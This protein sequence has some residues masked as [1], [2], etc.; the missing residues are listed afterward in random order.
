MPSKLWSDLAPGDELV[1]DDHWPLFATA[2]RRGA[3]V[4]ERI[5][6]ER[7]RVPTIWFTDGTQVPVKDPTI[8]IL[9]KGESHA[10]PGR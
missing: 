2:D 3:L 8:P 6:M 4:V 5:G 10:P 1:V 9:V 7:G